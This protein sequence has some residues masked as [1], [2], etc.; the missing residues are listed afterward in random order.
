MEVEGFEGVGGA[1][2]GM[3]GLW[4]FVENREEAMI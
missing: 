2:T 1:L 3:V 4:K